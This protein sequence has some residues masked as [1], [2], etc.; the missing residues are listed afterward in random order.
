M[1][2]IALMSGRSILREVN[3]K[4]HIE[5]LLFNDL[6]M[7]RALSPTASNLLIA[8]LNQLT[9]D[10]RG[11]VAFAGKE[12]EHIKR[13][14][15]LIGCLAFDVFVDHRARWKGMGF[16]SRMIPFAY[17]YGHELIAE[18]KD[19]IDLGAHPAKKKPSAKMPKH[20]RASGIAV[21]MNAERTRE[22]R[23]IAD[24][25]AS[26]LGQ[27]GIRLLMN[28]HALIRGRALLRKRTEVNDD[29]VR[30]LRAIDAYVSVTKCR[31]LNGKEQ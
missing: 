17:Q 14:V 29:D 6:T 2:A 13:P 27:L 12:V 7:I 9:Q 18:I 26:L 30:W 11:A 22:L 1:E 19:S 4:A 10:E 24:A 20:T 25:R 15:G 3:T 16:V 28:Y 21:T 31:A 23:R 8:M 5:F